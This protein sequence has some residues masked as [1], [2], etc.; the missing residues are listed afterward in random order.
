MPTVD[1]VRRSQ[2][3]RTSGQPTHRCA[4]LARLAA[5]LPTW[6]IP[7]PLRWSALRIS[8]ASFDHLVGAGEESWRYGQA[9]RLRGLQVD[10]EIEAC[11]LFNRKR[12][13]RCA[14]I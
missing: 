1:T 10:D 13:D 2:A 6:A 14:L 7:L 4:A 8:V 12:S 3:H 9:E 5:P 11:G